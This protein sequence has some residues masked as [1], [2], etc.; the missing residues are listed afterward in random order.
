MITLERKNGEQPCVLYYRISPYRGT[1]ICDIANVGFPKYSLNGTS[2]VFH[3]CFNSSRAS[4]RPIWALLALSF[5]AV[6][7]SPIWTWVC[8]FSCRLW[9]FRWF[10]LP[11]PYMENTEKW[12]IALVILCSCVKNCYN[13][14]KICFLKRNL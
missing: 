6:F 5:V 12:N 11:L 2:H 14:K 9:D 10:C 1:G 7:F 13:G 3:T 4:L 8:V